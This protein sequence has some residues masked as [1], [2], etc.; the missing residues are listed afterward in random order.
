MHVQCYTSILSAQSDPSARL[1]AGRTHSLRRL[2]GVLFR[3]LL[4][5]DYRGVVDG[6]HD[7]GQATA[8]VVGLADV[9]FGWVFQNYCVS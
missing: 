8:Q 4:N 9:D 1:F 5:D 6:L 7:G 3:A 2:L